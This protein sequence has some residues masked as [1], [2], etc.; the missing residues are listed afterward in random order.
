MLSSKFS[1][2]MYWVG[3]SLIILPMLLVLAGL[4][5]LAGWGTLAIVLGMTAGF[6]FCMVCGLKGHDLM[7]DAEYGED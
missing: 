4:A 2:P 1:K 5:M 7:M 3:I 6:V